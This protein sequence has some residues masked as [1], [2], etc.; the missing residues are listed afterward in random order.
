[1]SRAKAEDN[2]ARLETYLASVEALPARGGKVS[3]AA[4]ATAAGIDRQ[5]FYRNPRAKALL[6][7]A[8]ADKGLVGIEARAAGDRSDAEKALERQ[9]RSLESRNAALMAENAELRARLRRFE[10]IEEMAVLGKRVIP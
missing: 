9:V 4:I 8:V 1:M 6:D 7:A 10:H 2:L 3:V 5:V